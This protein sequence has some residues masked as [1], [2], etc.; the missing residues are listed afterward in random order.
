MKSVYYLRRLVGPQS[1]ARGNELR[2]V[3]TVVIMD[4][5]LISRIHLHVD[6]AGIATGLLVECETEA[7]HIGKMARKVAV[8][9]AMADSSAPRCTVFGDT[10]SVMY[11]VS[12]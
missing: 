12:M 10:K 5:R 9:W 7:T 3:P 8:I 2:M 1:L 4:S 11:H 6:C